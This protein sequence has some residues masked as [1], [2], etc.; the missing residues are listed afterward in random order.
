[1]L[2]TMLETVQIDSARLEDIPAITAIYNNVIATT[3]AV[4]SE[5]P[6]TIADRQAWWNDRS[7]KKLP[8]LVARNGGQ[9]LGYST[10]GD[11]RA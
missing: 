10:F 4:Y 5:N 1:M 3:T 2:S 6:V 11:F 9:C 7:L 8:V